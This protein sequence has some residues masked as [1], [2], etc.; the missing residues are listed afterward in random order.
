MDEWAWEQLRLWLS[1]R[2]QLPLG[3]LFCVI[4]GPT[5]GPPWSGA[6]VRGEFRRLAVLAGVRRRF[7]P[8]QLRHAHA[9]ELAREGVPLNISQRQLGHASLGTTSIPAT[10]SSRWL[11]ATRKGWPQATAV[12][13]IVSVVAGLRSWHR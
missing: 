1:A 2:A 12:L 13:R 7:A 4:A 5:R 6:A 10:A 9:L 3:P 8:H 11:P